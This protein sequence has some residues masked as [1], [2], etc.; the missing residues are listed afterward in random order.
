[1]QSSSYFQVDGTSFTGEAMSRYGTACWPAV[2][3]LVTGSPNWSAINV[4]MKMAVDLCMMEPGSYP[5]PTVTSTISPTATSA[6]TPTRT[7]TVTWTFTP[8]LTPVPPFA[9]GDAPLVDVTSRINGTPVAGNTTSS[10]NDY[11]RGAYGAGAPD[12]LYSFTLASPRAVTVS[13]CGSA[14][15]TFLYVRSQ[16]SEDASNIAVNDDSTVCGTS[17]R[18]SRVAQ[19]LDAGTYYVIVDGY[20]TATDAGAYTL[21]ITASP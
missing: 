3:G 2:T 9:C 13:L 5:S 19:F 21:S 10:L 7:P 11:S 20:S 16:C 15:D 8:S 14:F 12:D 1:M 18:Q 17:S 6:F 4:I